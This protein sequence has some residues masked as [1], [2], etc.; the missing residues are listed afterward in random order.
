[1]WKAN[2]KPTTLKL[3]LDRL[4]QKTE[5]LRLEETMDLSRDRLILEFEMPNMNSIC[6]TVQVLVRST[7]IQTT[8]IKKTDPS[9]SQ[10]A[11]NVYI[12]CVHPSNS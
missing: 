5:K 9:Y 3:F 10:G 7:Y 12:Q 4:S 8:R 1:M 2:G 11:Q 6:P